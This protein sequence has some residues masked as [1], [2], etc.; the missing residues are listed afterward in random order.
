LLYQAGTIEVDLEI[1]PSKIAGRLR[2]LGQVTTGEPSLTQVWVT[3]EGPSG[4]L[5]SE[6]DDLGQFMFD[7]L[8]AGDH[9]LTIDL[10][11]EVIIIPGVPLRPRFPL[12]YADLGTALGLTIQPPRA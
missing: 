6:T 7:R 8:L 4:H 12:D 1:S 2:L 3:A 10:A 9:Q 11:H 5:K